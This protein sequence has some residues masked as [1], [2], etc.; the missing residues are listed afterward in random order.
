M[1]WPKSSSARVATRYSSKR[2]W[3]SSRTKKATF[4]IARHTRI[5]KSRASSELQSLFRPFSLVLCIRVLYKGPSLNLTVYSRAELKG[6]DHRPGELLLNISVCSPDTDNTATVFTIFRAE[7]RVID[8]AKRA[9]LSH[10]LLE[11]VTS[12]APGEKLDEKLASLAFTTD[13][14][15]CASSSTKLSRSLHIVICSA[16]AQ[17]RYLGLVGRTRLV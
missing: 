9:S 15:D 7:L 5:S 10:L 17:F 3:K 4:T 16:T 6:S 2:P 14:P 12:T 1:Q 11:N 8:H 13:E